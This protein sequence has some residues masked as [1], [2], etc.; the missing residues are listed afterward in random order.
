MTALLLVFFTAL[1]GGA[2]GGAV[3]VWLAWRY[4]RDDVLRK[5][6]DRDSRGITGL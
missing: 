2:V 1:L 4:V 3:G 5:L 6:A